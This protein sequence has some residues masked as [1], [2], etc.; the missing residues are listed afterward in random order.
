MLW[1]CAEFTV[2]LRRAGGG[3]I[4]VT[5]LERSFR[6]PLEN[7]GRSSL[8]EFIAV[9]ARPRADSREMITSLDGRG[10]RRRETFW[11]PSRPRSSLFYRSHYRRRRHDGGS[12]YI[13]RPN[14]AG[15]R[16][17]RRL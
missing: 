10:G 11:A 1:L 4:V 6:A 3:A 2:P 17:W 16:R 7:A 8:S 14:F 5:V 15:A 12:T 9:F 13:P